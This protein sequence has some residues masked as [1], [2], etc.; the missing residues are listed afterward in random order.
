MTNDLMRDVIEGRIPMPFEHYP[1]RYLLGVELLPWQEE[2]LK[3]MLPKVHQTLDN[4]SH[5]ELGG[6]RISYHPHPHASPVN[7]WDNWG[8]TE[9]P[10]D[11]R[12]RA[13]RAKQERGTGPDV[14]ALK[15]RGRVTKYKEKR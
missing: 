8:K 6:M 3:R 7:G 15:E 5:A 14:G 4:M 1:R 11:P 9:P 10:T 13:L 2:Y 12:E